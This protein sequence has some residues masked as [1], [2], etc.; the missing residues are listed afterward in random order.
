MMR[1]AVHFLLTMHP[2]FVDA[3]VKA[4]FLKKCLEAGLLTELFEQ[5]QQKMISIHG[6]FMD[7]T[8]S[9]SGTEWAKCKHILENTPS[10]AFPPSFNPFFKNTHHGLER[11]L[12]GQEHHFTCRR[13]KVSPQHLHG[14]LQ[15]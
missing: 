7:E 1:I 6:R 10:H 5:I 9:E 8:A 2:L 15:A 11:W 13:L 12:S 3:A 4:P 14:G